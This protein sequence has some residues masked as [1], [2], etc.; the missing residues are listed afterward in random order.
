MGR[1]RQQ[2]N[3]SRRKSIPDQMADYR[4]SLRQRPVSATEDSQPDFDTDS[5]DYSPPS[6]TPPPK[7]KAAPS[8]KLH[9]TH[10]WI[11]IASGV[12]AILVMFG[13]AVYKFA[14]LSKGLE[15]VEKNVSDNKKELQD[16]I[17]KVTDRIDKFFS[18]EQKK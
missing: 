17:D 8:P 14:S 5:T 7:E 6:N 9:N 18:K 16:R 4:R 12:L 3:P 13:G 10:L 15:N 11:G 1:N 2:R